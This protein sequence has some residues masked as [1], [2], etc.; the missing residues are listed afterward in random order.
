[1]IIQMS[2]AEVNN[3]LIFLNRV[4]VTGLDEVSAL[5]IVV[6]KIN[7]A[8]QATQNPQTPQCNIDLPTK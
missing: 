8:I 6:G 5:G 1:M 3:L 7:E 2:E 4:S